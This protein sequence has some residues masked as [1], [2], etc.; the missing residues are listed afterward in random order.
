MKV[1]GRIA[2]CGMIS[3]YTLDK[4]EGVTNIMSLIYKRI[5]MQGYNVV[6]YYHLYDKFLEIILPYI[7]EGNIYCVEDIVEGLE[8]GALALV[9]VFKGLNIGKQV[10]SLA[11]E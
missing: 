9:G 6:D 7:R 11:N 4:P 5:S 2:V 8:N 3:Q 10:V 1:H